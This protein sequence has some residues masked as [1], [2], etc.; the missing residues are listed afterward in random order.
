[1]SLTTEYQTLVIDI[2]HINRVVFSSRDYKLSIPTPCQ[3]QKPSKI[4]TK[5]ELHGAF[6]KVVQLKVTI[7]G[8]NSKGV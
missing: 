1:M 3:G 8:S 4:A 7:S 6:M 5:A 2:P